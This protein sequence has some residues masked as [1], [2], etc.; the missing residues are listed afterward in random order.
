MA[1]VRNDALH[2]PPSDRTFLEPL[3]PP[4]PSPTKVK[5]N[6][7]PLF[8]TLTFATSL[9]SA[10]AI[11]P[12]ARTAL[13][14]LQSKAMTHYLRSRHEAILIGVGTAVA[15]D[16]GLN[17]RLQGVGGYGGRDVEGQPRPIIID[18]TA[19]WDFTEESKLFSL[20]DSGRGKAPFIITGEV[21]PTAEKKSIL[22]RK[23]GK[24]IH[25]NSTNATDGKPL[26]DWVDIFSAISDEGISSVMVEGGGAVINSLL[27]PENS[28]LVSSIVVTIAPT[29]LGRGGV[30]VSPSRRH[31]A[32]GHPIPVARLIE[33][34]WHPL[35][36]DVILTGKLKLR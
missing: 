32:R 20:V 35:G 2:F 24:Y 17:C 10:L 31:D 8:V 33:V 22:A 7:K 13:S 29:W 27:S 36:E 15:D 11:Q 5:S 34:K 14:G 3:L 26:I 19:R 6:E 30:I 12:G 28:S 21:N 1:D 23:G 18:P 9:D 25:V 4:P 16:P